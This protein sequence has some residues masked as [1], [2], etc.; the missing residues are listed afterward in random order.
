M[1]C[2]LCNYDN[3]KVNDS[4]ASSDGLSVKRRRECVKCG[5]RFSTVEEGEIF[6]MQVIKRNG[7]NELYNKE[8]LIHGLERALEKRNVTGEALH[9]LVKQI[10]R[11]IQK[12]KKNEVTSEEIG[13]IVMNHLKKFDQVAYIR[14]ASVYMSFEDVTGFQKEVQNLNNK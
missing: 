13:Q 14:F 10:E 3:T 2:P 5:Y 8:K 7:K 12:L 6:D 11:D 4:R 1:H 9:C